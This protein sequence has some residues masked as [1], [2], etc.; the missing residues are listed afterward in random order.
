VDKRFI[1]E[2]HPRRSV[3]L[4]WVSESGTQGSEMS[5]M[6]PG[7]LNKRYVLS[8]ATH[9][10]HPDNQ[11]VLFRHI[12]R[13]AL[14][15]RQEM[16]R[17]PALQAYSANFGNAINGKLQ[18]VLKKFSGIA[19]AADIVAQEVA[20][21]KNKKTTPTKPAANKAPATPKSKKRKV[22]K[23]KGEEVSEED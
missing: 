4:I 19:G 20:D 11:A 1:S 18:Q 13:A 9:T 2:V 7:L 22:V 8:G 23:E 3:V 14:I 5:V 15:S 17:D 12:V 21:L 6:T 10:V 16:Y